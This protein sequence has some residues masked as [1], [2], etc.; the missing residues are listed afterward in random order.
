MDET[1]LGGGRIILLEPRRVAARAAARFL[2]GSLGEGPGGLVGY[3]IR[4]ETRVS[5]RTRIEVVT[6]GV[7]TRML[8][9]DP[10]LDGTGLVVFD[11]FHERNLHADLGLALTLEA[12]AVLRA[13][14]RVLVMS[15]TLE[16]GPVSA[17]LGGAPIVTSEGRSWPVETRWRP[18]RAGRR[19]PEA[20]A[21]VVREAVAEGGGDVLAF[22]PGAGEIAR[23]Q[24][25]LL[26]PPI[27]A[28][29]VPL[30]GSLPGAE[31]DRAL[32]PS[33][34]RRVV[35]ATNVAETSLTIDGVRTVVDGGLARVPRYSPRTGMTRLTTVR[36]S[37]SSADQ[38]R[39]RAGRQG[40]GVCYRLWAAA[41]DH[42]L[43]ARSTPEILEADLAPL[44]LELAVAGRASPDGL[45]WLDPPPAAAFQVA[46]DL[47]RQLGALD[48]E[49]KVTP[50]GRAMAR[51]G[52]H[53]RLA[54]LLLRGRELGHGALAADLAALLTER[55]LF[56]RAGEPGGEI[57]GGGGDADLRARVHALR[58]RDARADP[59]LVHRVRSEA[60]HF[61]QAIEVRDDAPADDEATGLLVS[62]AYPD[63]VARR[64]GD[65]PRYLLRN[66]QG[67]VLTA[68]SLAREE[69]L[70]CADLDG[71]QRESRI[72][73][74][75]PVTESEVREHF[76]D[77]L[78]V[79]EETAF[80]ESH[81]TVS[82]RRI[83]RLGAIVLR[84]AAV[85]DGDR[86]AE[87]EVLLQRL[88]S[89]GLAGL[90]WGESGLAL[91]Q[92]LAFLH[93]V[94]GTWPDVT[95]PA[96][97]A[98]AD[99]WLRGL[100]ARTRRLTDLDPGDLAE[101]LLGL[102]D[103]RQRAALDAAAPSHLRV[104]SGSRIAVDYSNPERPVMSV[105]VQEVF[106]WTETPRLAGGRVPVTFELLS[107][108]RR[109]VQVTRDLAGFWRHGWAEV[110]KE[111]RGRYP[112][113]DWPEDPARATATHGSAKRR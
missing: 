89:Q 49:G 85:R 20:V 4:R 29:V 98:R 103:W 80:D 32:R 62:L 112:K 100:L 92:R 87:A 74:A 106:G 5:D 52:T 81:G 109:P 111:L 73:L 88:H 77:Q 79:I 26:D 41:E 43:L 47:L 21:A 84:T 53:P 54:H 107:P 24:A 91:R 48:Q 65:S 31:Q 86:V 108:A 71:H 8:Q 102:L 64:R 35:L 13:E 11:E 2:A 3:R 56:G 17:L 18:P 51:L 38:R 82:T 68:P 94:D 113:H 25:L 78:E 90:P 76:A 110:R 40:A 69:W 93:Q 57:E 50:H 72:R 63:R 97:L 36:V 55:D 10:G 61:R 30:H 75:A 34:R 104:P 58:S 9:G 105:R 46:R 39:G 59:A 1:W 66:G 67:A 16:G 95:D 23:V 33:S 12:R 45:A 44:A 96:L 27:E 22:L 70:A 60:R 7:L 37:R 99:E 28:E 101:A 83:E 6:E 19:H 42:H 15:A 14:L